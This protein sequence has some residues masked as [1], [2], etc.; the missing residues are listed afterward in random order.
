VTKAALTTDS[1]LS[2]SSF[3]HTIKVPRLALPSG[4]KVT[5]LSGLLKENVTIMLDPGGDGLHIYLDREIAVNKEDSAKFVLHGAAD[6]E[7]SDL[8]RSIDEDAVG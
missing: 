8:T 4:C 6:D 7:G 2:A 3:Q 5:A 1:F